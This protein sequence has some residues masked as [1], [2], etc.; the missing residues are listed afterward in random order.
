MQ[1]MMK[2]A[3]KIMD[4]KGF[5]IFVHVTFLVLAAF[6][7]L[8]NFGNTP[9]QHAVAL[10]WVPILFISILVHE[11]GHAVAIQ[12]Y[13]Y[14]R[15]QILLWGMGGLCISRGRRRPKDGIRIALAGPLFGFLLGL[16]FLILF[17]VQRVIGLDL[18]YVLNHLVWGMVMVN[19]G[20]TIMNLFP[21][22]PLDGG[23]A[24]YY[25][26]R[27]YGKKTA[28]K[29]ARLSGLIGLISLVPILLL[30]FV[31]QEFF[32]IFLVL[33]MAPTSYQAWRYG[34]GAIQL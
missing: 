3:R 17:I 23:Q 26:L 19:I 33:F 13:G 14:G 2:G 28:D 16:P 15:S 27:L 1:N 32:L 24:L 12:K 5:P 21:I 34:H 4:L 20:W 18:G 31:L 10:A 8:P 29:A 22:F 25:G 6:F 9:N 30:A 7:V 11:L